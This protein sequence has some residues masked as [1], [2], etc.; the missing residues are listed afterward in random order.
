MSNN[1]V[2]YDKLVTT[3]VWG[4]HPGSVIL[5]RALKQI[6]EDHDH[7]IHLPTMSQ[8]QRL[9]SGL[10]V[11][12]VVRGAGVQNPGEAGRKVQLRTQIHWHAES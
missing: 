10:V 6:C 1:L 4:N 8:I 12:L 9:Q 5:C 3:S 11:R 7:D 2:S